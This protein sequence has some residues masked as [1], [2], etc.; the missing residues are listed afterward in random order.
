[1]KQIAKTI[2]SC[3][4]PEEQ[5]ESLYYPKSRRRSKNIQMVELNY[6]KSLKGEIT[7]PGDKSISHR[8]VILGSIANGVTRINHF[9]ESADC[10]A[11]IDCLEKMGIEVKREKSQILV[12]GRGMGGL[13]APGDTLE[14]GNSGT[15]ARLLTGILAGQPFPSKISGDTSLNRRP[16]NRI[17]TPLKQMNACVS[18]V[19]G[20]NCAPL[21]VKPSL[22]KG[23]HYHSPVAS[24]QVK[25]CILLAGL[26]AKGTT[27]VTEPFLSRNHTE[28]MLKE[29]G[30]NI[31]T[32]WDKTNS[33]SPSNTFKVEGIEN[34]PSHQ[35][36][37]ILTPGEA[38]HGNEIHVPG[39]IS[40]AAFFIVAGLIVPNS[41]V[42]IKNVGVNPTR[43]GILKI[44]QKMGGNVTLENK[45]IQNGEP[46]ADISVKSSSLK[47]IKI[48][49]EIIPTLIDEIPIIA[50]MAA[51]A[52][53]QTVIKDARELKVKESNRIDTV[54]LNLK[55]MGADIVA[56][57]DG[58]R[59]NGRE[60][61]KGTLIQPYYDHRIAMAF[62]IAALVAKGSAKIMDSH[63]V[64]VSYPNFFDTL[65]SLL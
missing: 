63:C 53:G 14:V 23:I 3:P 44:C 18:S 31:R 9:L 8:G 12:Y 5:K 20:N 40:S 17:L 37:A 62:S 54:V 42:L 24:A 19:M 2:G 47:G 36:T 45:R 6:V 39:D 29:F 11:T 10:L 57:E 28:L 64:N 49:G 55:N 59:I 13:H 38:L 30:A 1:M 50:V 27:S 56:T 61:L 26:Y 41:E 21:V 25:S 16:M 35:P 51:L 58:M 52:E 46:V 32:L 7:I 4:K 60:E 65:H 15:T 43:S 22:L 34:S 33:L 48:E